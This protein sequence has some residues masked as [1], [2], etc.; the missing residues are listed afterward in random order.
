MPRKPI[1]R[2]V[3]EIRFSA[4]AIVVSLFVLVFWNAARHDALANFVASAVFR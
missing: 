4:I 3:N 2:S 1:K